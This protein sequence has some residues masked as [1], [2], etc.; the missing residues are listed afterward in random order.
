M[1]DTTTLNYAW[2]KPEVG[3]SPTTWGT[4]L[5]SDLDLIDA[6]VFALSNFTAANLNLTSAPATPVP[7][8]VTFLN[9][10]APA[11]QQKRWAWTE[12]TTSET[13]GNVGSNFNLQ[14]FSDAGAA[15]ATP[16]TVNRA[17]GAVSIIGANT[18]NAP[19]A[20]QV[21]EVI[22]AVLLSANALS[23]V[24]ATP[25]N[26]LTISLTPGD[27]DVTG[28]VWFSGTSVPVS[29]HAGLTTNSAVLPQDSS[30]YAARHSL[31]TT[32]TNADQVLPLRACRALV[33][34]AT[35]YYLIAQGA[36]TAGTLTAFGNIIA[37]RRR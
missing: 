7:A 5:N 14:S 36:F 18:A 10:A 21:G 31:W 23:L 27:W 6:Q 17:S 35:P 3:A 24:T 32:F 26:V 1:A 13:G 28:E 15:L 20:G 25:I 33:S 4:K 19:V 8:T 29:A 22:S 2:V 9:G 12:D 34:V 30:T 11:G 37:R 16:I